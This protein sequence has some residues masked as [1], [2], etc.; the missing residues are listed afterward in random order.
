[1]KKT[2]TA[3]LAKL[4]SEVDLSVRAGRRSEARELLSQLQISSIPRGRACEISNLA[5]RCG[6]F[7]FG[8]QLMRPIIRPKVKASTEPTSSEKSTYSLLL[9]GVGAVPEAWEL[10]ESADQTSAEIKLSKAFIQINRWNYRAAV[11]L[12]RDY[13]LI[14]KDLYQKTV[15]QVNLAASLVVIGKAVEARE[16]LNSIH[17]TTSQ[18]RWSLL[19]KN[20]HEL[21]AQIA[22]QEKD[23]NLA[24]QLLNLAATGNNDGAGLDDL[25]VQ[26]WKAF[27]S[28]LR[29]PQSNDALKAVLAVRKAAL[30]S[31]HWETVRD[32]DFHQAIATRD[33]NLLVNVYY[34]SQHPSFKERLENSSAG[35]TEIPRE[36]VWQMDAKPSSRIFDLHSA[37]EVGGTA[38][39]KPGKSLHLALKVLTSDSYRPFL[40]GS[41]HN[42][43]F[44]GDHFNP[45]S[46]LRRVA[47][48]I[49]RL[50]AWLKENK[51][52]VQVIVNEQGYRL[53]TTGPYAF[54][55]RKNLETKSD[56]SPTHSLRM[57]EKLLKKY[58]E[59]PISVTQIAEILEISVRS[60]RYFAGWA[61]SSGRAKKLG[62]GRSTQYIMLKSNCD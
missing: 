12:L 35:W 24:D 14:A 21:S 58:A 45:D 16:L 18:N 8:L 43:V 42:A 6:M 5:R 1:M 32:C 7:D 20:A 10:L 49:H 56:D 17:Q 28:I 25:F 55:L 54:L 41:L 53:Q 33:P 9:L 51:I 57:H 40:V 39:L 47:F 11:P 48:L 2:A 46:S 62:S 22:I 23:W 61:V 36:S 34:G 52:P 38:K 50:R 60:A 4:I 19:Q 31:N 13:L 26:K 59:E 15:A 29:N 44:P 3:N 37:E 30:N 27:A